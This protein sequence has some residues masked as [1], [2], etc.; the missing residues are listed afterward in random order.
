MYDVQG[1]E[2]KDMVAELLA[3]FQ[4]TKRSAHGKAPGVGG[5]H[6]AQ[7]HLTTI[8]VARSQDRSKA[9]SGKR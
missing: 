1:K 7:S 6:R 8:R 9:C 4:A 3:S 2:D 5:V